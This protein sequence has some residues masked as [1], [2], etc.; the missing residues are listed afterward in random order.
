M[1]TVWLQTTVRMRESDVI[2]NIKQ[3]FSERG[4]NALFHIVGAGKNG[5]F[6]HHKTSDTVLKQ[7]DAVVFDSGGCKDGIV[8]DITRMMFLGARSPDY[9]I[10]HQIVENVLH[11]A[12]Q[13]VRPGVLAKNVDAAACKV[14]EQAGYGE[15]FVRSLGHW[16]GSE[17]HEKPHLSATSDTVL[18]EGM[19]FSIEPGI[20]L[21]KKIWCAP[22][23]YFN[24]DSRQP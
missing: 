22:R 20:F 5:A 12:L 15:Y 7:G 17:V 10:V 8:S 19:V 16:L 3:S 9:L 24:S 6:P 1:Q 13:T 14:I 23:R 21:P 18:E 4:T 11:A 2:T